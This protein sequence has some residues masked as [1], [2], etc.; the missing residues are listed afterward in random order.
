MKIATAILFSAVASWASSLALAQAAGDFPNRPV[1]IVVGFPPGGSSDVTARI[2]AE[3]M[4]E[5][6]KQPVIVENKPGAGATIAAASVANAPADGYTLLHLGPGTHAI[7]SALYKNLSYDAVRSFVGVG[8]IAVSPFVVVVG[9]ASPVKSMQDLLALARSKPGQVSYAS[10]GSGA[11]P[12]LVTETIA[13]AA[14]VKFLHVPFKGAAPAAAAALAGQVDF[15]MVDSASA[16]PHV[17]S[18]KL[19]ALALTTA[20]HSP[21]YRGVPTVAEAAVPGFAYPSSVGISAPAGTPREVVQKINAALN[22]A[23][24]NEGARGRL[25]GLGF[26]A[27]PM[28]ADEFNAFVA[29]EVEKYTKIV[30]DLGLKLD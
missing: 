18:G 15:A 22:R 1:R 19:R 21:L 2:V 29:G 3:R 8:Q 6:W 11:G 27:A 5:E 17:Q 13:S 9:A 7:S 30:K 12:H 10:S 20:N 4:S 23:L 28:T 25:N 16:I 14:G 24:A 26:E